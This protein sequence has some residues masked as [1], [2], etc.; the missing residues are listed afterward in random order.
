MA[1]SKPKNDFSYWL[2]FDLSLNL[3]LSYSFSETLIQ[4]V[5]YPSMLTTEG[6]LG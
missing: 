4:K 5:K 2:I 1:E 3:G 6:W